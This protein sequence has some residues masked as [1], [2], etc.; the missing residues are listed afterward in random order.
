MNATTLNSEI[1]THSAYKKALILLTPTVGFGTFAYN[2]LLP[3]LR[4]TWSGRK[5]PE[6]V[7]NFHA[8][9]G[10]MGD[11]MSYGF[12]VLTLVAITFLIAERNSL[13]WHKFREPVL[14]GF[15]FLA[16]MFVLFFTTFLAMSALLLA[17]H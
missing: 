10:L 8:F 15:A 17:T 14:F 2:K 16:N 3:T 9:I 5:L 6:T 12:I 13:S 4:S 1:S 11:V 7:N